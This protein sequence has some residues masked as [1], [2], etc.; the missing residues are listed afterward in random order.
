MEKTFSIKENK[1]IIIKEAKKK[2]EQSLIFMAEKNA[3]QA[4]TQKIYETQSNVSLINKLSKK[5]R[6]NNNINLIEVYDNSHIQ[7]TD[8]IGGLI[9]FGSEG[10]VKKK[11]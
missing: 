11:I 8:C 1:N 9:T 5:F 10:F 4:L 3:R 6:L 7:G 2:E